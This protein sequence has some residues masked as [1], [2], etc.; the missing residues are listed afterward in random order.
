MQILS[1]KVA[2]SSLGPYHGLMNLIYIFGCLAA[3]VVSGGKITEC[4][5]ED[6]YIGANERERERERECNKLG[7]RRITHLEKKLLQHAKLIEREGNVLFSLTSK[8]IQS[9]GRESKVQT[10]LYSPI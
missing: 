9:M 1:E 7:H 3:A 10:R 8:S 2:A 6:N 4:D 5:W